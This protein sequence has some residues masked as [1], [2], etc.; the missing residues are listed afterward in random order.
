MPSQ[1]IRPN[2]KEDFISA[3]QISRPVL[4]FEPSSVTNK[5]FKGTIVLLLGGYLDEKLDSVIV[6]TKG[7]SNSTITEVNKDECEVI[8]QLVDSEWRV[9][10]FESMQFAKP[11]DTPVNELWI[12][13]YAEFVQ[14]KFSEQGKKLY[15]IG[16]SSG[17]YIVGL[18]LRHLVEGRGKGSISG[19][20]IFSFSVSIGSSVKKTNFTPEHFKIST[21]FLSG[22]SK[23]DVVGKKPDVNG[24][25]NTRRIYQECALRSGT[26]HGWAALK[27]GHSIFSLLSED[28]LELANQGR[29]RRAVTN[30][31]DNWFGADKFPGRVLDD[32]TSF[33]SAKNPDNF[34]PQI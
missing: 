31:I 17:A 6:G 21:L 13:D 24:Y 23:L 25:S 30:I 7:W 15:M 27:V 26:E 32:G 22:S 1:N 33:E 34:I 8:G 9:I 5:S 14:E 3:A 28:K 4:V 19:Y 16:F 18:H 2:R 20:G 29:E 12:E 11:D 10:I